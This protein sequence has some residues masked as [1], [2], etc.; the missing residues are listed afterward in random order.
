MIDKSKHDS[1][2][3]EVYYLIGRATAPL[4]VAEIYERSELAIDIAKVSKA[5]YNLMTDKRIL[6]DDCDGRARYM[7][8]PDAKAAAP[9]GNTGRPATATPVDDA[10][11]KIAPYIPTLGEQLDA[12][13]EV[14]P[15]NGARAPAQKKTRADRKTSPDPVSDTTAAI[16]ADA[17]IARLKR[18]LGP[19]LHPPV[20]GELDVTTAPGAIHISVQ[21]VEINISIGADA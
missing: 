17:I 1:L 19:L 16:L 6:R 9:A 12:M 18:D 21:S 13:S 8:A 15:D 14:A 3:A 2:K 7:L 11:Q 20:V 10:A 4:T 5:I